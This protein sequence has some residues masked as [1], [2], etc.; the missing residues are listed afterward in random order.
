MRNERH[1]IELKYF[2]FALKGVENA[3]LGETS[4]HAPLKDAAYFTRQPVEC[5][6][7]RQ[8]LYSCHP[9]TELYYWDYEVEEVTITL[10]E[11]QCNRRK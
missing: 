11:G 4:T 2:V 6:Q 3:Y 7:A 1:R 9:D 5:L 10:I 8:L